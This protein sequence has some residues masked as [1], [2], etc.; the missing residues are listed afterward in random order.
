ME[1]QMKVVLS[2]KLKDTPMESNVAIKLSAKIVTT[3]VPV[4]NLTVTIYIL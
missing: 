2:I 1:F 3:K 4:G